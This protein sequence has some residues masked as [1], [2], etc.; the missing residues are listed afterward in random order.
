MQS[1]SRGVTKGSVGVN[2]INLEL[3]SLEEVAEAVR[4]SQGFII[5]SPTL[6]GHMPTQASPG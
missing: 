1:I 4:D 2:M 6:G 5:G 3:C